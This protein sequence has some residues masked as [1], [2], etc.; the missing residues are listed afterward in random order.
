MKFISLGGCCEVTTALN[1][2]PKTF[3]LPHS[4][5]D[6]C[7]TDTFDIIINLIKNNFHEITNCT[8][9]SILYPD[10]TLAA[11][12]KCLKNYDMFVGHYKE[13]WN[14]ISKRRISRFLNLLKNSSEKLIFV[15]KNHI[16][17]KITNEQVNSFKSCIS[18]INPNLNFELLIVQEY[19]LNE[20]IKILKN[21]I[22]HSVISDHP[23]QQ[24]GKYINKTRRGLH[25]KF[26]KILNDYIQNF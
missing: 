21:C 3:T 6:W 8:H 14:E 4:P 23:N 18:E 22:F 16:H 1:K 17:Q 12:G 7:Y 24:S 20:E 11:K 5:F 9:K 15:R 26:E 19:F 2:I 25:I 13:R 10:N